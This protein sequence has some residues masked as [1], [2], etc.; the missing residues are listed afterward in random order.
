MIQTPDRVWQSKGVNH[1]S[2][3]LIILLYCLKDHERKHCGR[4]VATK[5]ITTTFTQVENDSF[6]EIGRIFCFDIPMGSLEGFQSQVDGWTSLVLVVQ[7][8]VQ[9]F[10]LA[11]VCEVFGNNSWSSIILSHYRQDDARPSEILNGPNLQA[12]GWHV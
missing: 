2:L 1:V 4:A 9:G 5:V 7:F 6:V 10:T 11:S 12:F 3:G 8:L